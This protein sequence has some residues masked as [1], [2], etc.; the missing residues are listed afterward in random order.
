MC[1]YLFVTDMIDTKGNIKESYEK[2][3]LKIM[4]GMIASWKFF[5]VSRPLIYG[6][7]PLFFRNIAAYVGCCVWGAIFSYI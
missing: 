5:A 4:P 2:L 1:M 7:I 6:L 3:K